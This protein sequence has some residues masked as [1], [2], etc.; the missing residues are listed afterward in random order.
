MEGPDVVLFRSQPSS[1]AGAEVK[2][3]AHR[4]ALVAGSHGGRRVAGCRCLSSRRHA[5]DSGGVATSLVGAYAS[6]FFDG[7]TGGCIVT[8][9]TLVF[10]AVFAFAPKHGL[11]AARRRIRLATNAS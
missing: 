9:Q 10:L 1:D 8:L 3:A 2:S 11:L 5:G 6:Y 4:A 7:A